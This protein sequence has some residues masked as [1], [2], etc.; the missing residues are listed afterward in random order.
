MDHQHDPSHR[1]EREHK[2]AEHKPH[3]TPGRLAS[4]HPAWYVVVGVI[5]CG[6]ALLIWMLLW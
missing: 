4:V 5:L 3:G 6:S 1:Q 2:K